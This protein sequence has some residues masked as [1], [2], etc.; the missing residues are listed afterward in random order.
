MLC[1][2]FSYQRVQQK[3]YFTIVSQTALRSFTDALKALPKS[4]AYSVLALNRD[5]SV[6]VAV[7]P[8]VEFYQ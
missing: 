6:F 1:A 2:A 5:L 7:H 4:K 3:T 8:P